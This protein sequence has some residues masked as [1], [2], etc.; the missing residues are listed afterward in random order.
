MT[1]YIPQPNN[2][3][4]SLLPA[5]QW[6]YNDCI[7]YTSDFM[8]TNRYKLTKLNITRRIICEISY[9]MSDLHAILIDLIMLI[10]YRE[11]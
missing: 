3:P 6:T 1:T 9:L 2:L 10:G 7:V 5:K 8:I 4:Q 11:N